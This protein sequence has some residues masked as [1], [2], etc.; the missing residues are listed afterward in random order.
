M[1]RQLVQLSDAC[2]I[3]HQGRHHKPSVLRANDG[4]L[5][6]NAGFVSPVKIPEIALRVE[7][8]D[9]IKARLDELASHVVSFAKGSS[10]LFSLLATPQ[11]NPF[12]MDACSCKAKSMAAR[13]C[14]VVD[15]QT[16][17]SGSD[18]EINSSISVQPRI[19]ASVP[20]SATS[21]ITRWNSPRD[22]GRIRPWHNS[23]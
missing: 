3:A 23:R 10:C 13:A 8:P 7:H 17:R 1:S 12:L 2:A 21:R 5:T 20:A 18:S 16:G 19:T 11:P 15:A 4:P 9:Q 22:S 14:M 6:V